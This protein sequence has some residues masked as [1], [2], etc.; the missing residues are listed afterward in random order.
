[1]PYDEKLA[2]RV[3]ALL[4]ERRGVEEKSIMGHLAFMVDGSMC[5]SVSTESILFRVPAKEREE[6]LENPHVT[7]MKMGKRTMTGFVRVAP[8]AYRTAGALAKWVERGI[9]AGSAKPKRART[10]IVK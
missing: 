8:P 1:M 2:A 9:A 7:A 3:R 4:S 5:C 10:R 6:L